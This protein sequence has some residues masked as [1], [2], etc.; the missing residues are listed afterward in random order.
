MYAV[1]KLLT[2]LDLDCLHEA[3]QQNLTEQQRS[4]LEEMAINTQQIRHHNEESSFM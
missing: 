4:G 3:K 1:C 2:D